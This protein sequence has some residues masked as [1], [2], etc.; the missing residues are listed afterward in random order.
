MKFHG[1]AMDMPLVR[2]ISETIMQSI[3]SLALESRRRAL[4]TNTP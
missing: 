3:R 2:S 4:V 1:N